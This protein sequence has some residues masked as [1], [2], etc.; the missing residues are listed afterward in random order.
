M[1]A[2]FTVAELDELHERRAAERR[3][4]ARIESD[5]RDS[6]RAAADFAALV[7]RLALAADDWRMLSNYIDDDESESTRI[8]RERFAIRET[9]G[10]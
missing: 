7:E 3:G 9:V 1:R 5:R 6:R 8:T 2:F 10:R 4:E